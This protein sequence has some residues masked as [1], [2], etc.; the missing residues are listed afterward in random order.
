M[1]EWLKGHSKG[2]EKYGQRHQKVERQPI[3]KLVY[4]EGAK[5]KPKI[6]NFTLNT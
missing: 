4:N 2:R 1:M 3:L 6:M 5:T